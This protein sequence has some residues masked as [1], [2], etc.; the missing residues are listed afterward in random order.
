MRAERWFVELDRRQI[1]DGESSRVIQVQ[2]VHLGPQS[3]WVQVALADEPA[4]GVVLHV[5]ARATPA[6]AIA[7]LQSWLSTPPDQ[8]PHVV[9]VMQLR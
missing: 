5:P 2:A 4:S 7:A 6:H 3:T 8:R 1:G 9:E